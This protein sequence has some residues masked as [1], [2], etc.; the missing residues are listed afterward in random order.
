MKRTLQ[1]RKVNPTETGV[2][3]VEELTPYSVA[4]S[5]GGGDELGC[6]HFSSRRRDDGT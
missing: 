2:G 4:E 6:H 5:L 3:R 1:R